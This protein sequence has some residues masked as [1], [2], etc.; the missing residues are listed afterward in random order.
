M[1]LKFDKLGENWHLPCRTCSPPPCS[2]RGNTGERS[3]KIY[4]VRY[5]LIVANFLCFLM[6]LTG[7]PDS[8]SA[9]CTSYS[10]SAPLSPSLRPRSMQVVWSVTP[11]IWTKIVA[12]ISRKQNEKWESPRPPIH[13]AGSR[14][15]SPPALGD[16]RRR[17]G[18]GGLQNIGKMK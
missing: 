6:Y 15:A 3:S 4:K 17:Q 8:A 12:K 16:R 1:L 18:W 7:S 2:P 11:G 9:C 13:P 14:G 5:N 10:A